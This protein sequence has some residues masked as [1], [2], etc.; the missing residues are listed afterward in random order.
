MTVLNIN[1]MYITT[2]AD[3]YVQINYSLSLSQA[4]GF[5]FNPR[6]RLCIYYVI[7]VYL[8]CELSSAYNNYMYIGNLKTMLHLLYCCLNSSLQHPVTLSSS[9]LSVLYGIH[10]ALICI[11]LLHIVSSGSCHYCK[12]DYC[13]TPF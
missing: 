13:A 11:T 2:I 1:N 7:F 8:G 12:L 3:S 10:R 4:R 6:R 5:E 9:H